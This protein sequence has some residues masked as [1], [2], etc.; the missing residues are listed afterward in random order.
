MNNDKN[1]KVDL[2]LPPE[3][4][5]EYETILFSTTSS[6]K[7][8]EDVCMTLAHLPTKRAQDLLV[9]FKGTNRALE[10][11]WLDGAID[12]GQMWYL[13]P[14]TDVEER[15]YLALK[16]IQ[17]IEDELVGLHIDLND[18]KVDLEKLEIE[19]HAIRELIKSKNISEN[20]GIALHDIR[21]FYESKFERIQEQIDLKEKI[22][23]Q[24]RDSIQTA[25]YKNL[26]ATIMR[27][28]E[29]A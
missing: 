1:P 18:A 17:E 9:K 6:V 25:R 22:L 14:Q 5:E 28:I 4:Y 8:L 20:E 15:D 21:I 7:E 10:V 19:H 27:G 23:Q 3:T 24:I 26:D 13:D 16:M 12:E 11:K 29:F 2:M